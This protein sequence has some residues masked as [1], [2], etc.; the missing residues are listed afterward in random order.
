MI[1][2]KFISDHDDIHNDI[3]KKDHVY[4]QFLGFM[5]GDGIS[6]QTKARLGITQS[7]IHCLGLIDLLGSVGVNNPSLS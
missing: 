4:Y 7:S 1:H 6:F 2:S 3:Q 5:A